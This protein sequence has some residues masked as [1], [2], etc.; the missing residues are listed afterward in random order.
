MNEGGPFLPLLE[1]AFTTVSD[2][3]V[4]GVVRNPM[5]DLDFSTLGH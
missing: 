2:G 4:K 5:T 3:S 1:P